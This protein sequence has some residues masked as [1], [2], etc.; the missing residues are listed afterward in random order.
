M[1]HI[2]WEWEWNGMDR[3]CINI[4]CTNSISSGRLLVIIA[5]VP[6]PTIVYLRRQS[7]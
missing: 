6:G 3:K 2:E 1:W 4:I 5:V 7:Y